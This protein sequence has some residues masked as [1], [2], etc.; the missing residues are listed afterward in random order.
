M[1]NSISSTLEEMLASVQVSSPCNDAWKLIP[2]SKLGETAVPTSFPPLLLE[3]DILHGLKAITSN[4]LVIYSGK[5]NP[6]SLIY[7]GQ[8]QFLSK[9]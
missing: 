8:N 4:F 3:I 2:G 5:I 9:S 7:P 6:N 1:L